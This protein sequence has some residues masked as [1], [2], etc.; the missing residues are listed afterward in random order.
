VV[1]QQL[2]ITMEEVAAI[3][4][5]LNDFAMIRAV[6]LGIAMGNAQEELKAVSRYVTQSNDED[7]VAIAIR[8]ILQFQATKEV[9]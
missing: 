2:G 5:S 9:I 7:G 1:C 8:T 6:G 3:G 4:D